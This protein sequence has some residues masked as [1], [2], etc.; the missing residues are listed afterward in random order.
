M[1]YDIAMVVN[2]DI[3]VS[4][5]KIALRNFEEWQDLIR[6]GSSQMDPALP[7]IPIYDEQEQE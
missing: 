4:R 1:S 5:S 6:I 7:N 3:R 2:A